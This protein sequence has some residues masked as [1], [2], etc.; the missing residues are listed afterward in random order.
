MTWNKIERRLL[1][2]THRCC[3]AISTNSFNIQRVLCDHDCSHVTLYCTIQADLLF[4]EL[5]YFH[6]TIQ[7]S[8]LFSL[9]LNS[10]I[11]WPHKTHRAAVLQCMRYCLLYYYVE[12]EANRVIEVKWWNKYQ[13]NNFGLVDCPQTSSTCMQDKHRVSQEAA[14]QNL[15]FAKHFE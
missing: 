4:W 12:S 7:Y 15:I 11:V 5:F 1:I 14:H 6:T 13:G 3:K 9:L 2:Y 8:L 10:F